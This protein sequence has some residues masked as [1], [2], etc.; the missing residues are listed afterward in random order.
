MPCWA[1]TRSK[2]CAL[3]AAQTA[4]D[5]IPSPPRRQ[6]AAV[7]AAV[8]ARAQSLIAQSRAKIAGLES[9]VRAGARWAKDY[10]AAVDGAKRYEARAKRLAAQAQSRARQLEAAL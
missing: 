5:A 3:S 8:L 7:K 2:L 1:Q 10:Q 9:C 6:S 4:V